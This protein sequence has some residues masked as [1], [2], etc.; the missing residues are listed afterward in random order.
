MTI[1]EKKV[2]L[3]KLIVE[4]DEEATGKLIE[5]AH[6]LSKKTH[7]FSEDEIAMFQKTRD[8]FFASGKNGYSVEE[9]HAT[10]RNRVKQ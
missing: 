8:N 4:A 5:L 10:I 7:R 1:A 9:A 3:F 2:E 6:Q